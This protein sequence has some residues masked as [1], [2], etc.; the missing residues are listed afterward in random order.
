MLSLD[1]VKF[2]ESLIISIGT[3]QAE[4]ERSVQLE[5]KITKGEHKGKKSKVTSFLAIPKV[6]HVYA[7][8]NVIFFP[9]RG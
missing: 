3:S 6:R 7:L 1:R 5:L 9:Y 4:K 2:L 8:L